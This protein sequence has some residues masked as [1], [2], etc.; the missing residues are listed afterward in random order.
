MRNN[1]LSI[2]QNFVNNNALL[3]DLDSPLLLN[4]SVQ[5]NIAVWHQTKL[6]FFFHA[7]ARF[8]I[9]ICKI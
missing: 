1:I 8:L 5:S 9:V 2:P 6:V 7:I 3:K 4:G